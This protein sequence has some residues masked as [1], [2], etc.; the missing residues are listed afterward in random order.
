VVKVDLMKLKKIFFLKF[1]GFGGDFHI[2]AIWAKN[3][4]FEIIWAKITYR[5]SLRAR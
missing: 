2:W 3:T 4:Y 1:L 5:D